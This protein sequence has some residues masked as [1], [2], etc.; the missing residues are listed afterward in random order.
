MMHTSAPHLR[1]E[2]ELITGMDDIPLLFDPVSGTYHRVSSAG[3]A[4]LTYLDGTHTTDDLVSMMA[5]T[6][7][8]IQ[9]LRPQLDDF[10]DTL[11]N[12]G[13]LLGSPPP[14]KIGSRASSSRLMPRVVV[15]RSLPGLL[16]PLAGLLRRMPL[17]L[18]SALLLLAAVSGFT[19]GVLSV[20]QNG[21]P[22]RSQ[23]GLAFLVA[24]AT[25][26]LLVLIHECAHAVVAQVQKVPIR[27]LGFAML[28]YFMPIAYVDRT[29]AYR[30]RGRG[31]RIAIALAGMTS[32]GIF[33]GVSTLVVTQTT[34]FVHHVAVLLVGLQLIGLAINLNPLLP[35]DGYTALEVSTGLVDF[36][37]RAFALVRNTV[38][39]RPMPRHLASLSPRAR[40]AYASYALITAIY[41]AAAASFVLTGT[42][43]SVQAA[44][45]QAH[46]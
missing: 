32:D 25:Q 46:R 12:S 21:F 18:L 43:H 24:A 34:G 45:E 37:G 19:A 30:L 17:R 39:R 16:E 33:C 42:V 20:V 15:T 14:P 13:L 8:A 36:R 3:Q 27:G 41:I 9:R 5:P 26:L 2:L 23:V 38:L 11:H 7:A 6:P 4:V 35:G 31:G 22:P 40:L 10:L 1:D 29:D 28:F 44:I